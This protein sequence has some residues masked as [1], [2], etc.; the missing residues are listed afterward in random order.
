MCSSQY[1]S[2]NTCNCRQN[3]ACTIIES[4]LIDSLTNPDGT[5]TPLAGLMDQLNVAFTVIF[6]I[7]L[8]LNMFSHWFYPF[9]T[10]T[11]S[12]VLVLQNMLCNFIQKTSH[13]SF[14]RDATLSMVPCKAVS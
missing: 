5:P 3:F 11:W 14:S 9:A 1:S 2:A 8:A 4:E 7:E 13:F 12:Q 10:N 6:T